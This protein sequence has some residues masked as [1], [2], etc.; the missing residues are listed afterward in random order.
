M[1]S[2]DLIL[3][4]VQS[5]IHGL[6]ALADQCDGCSSIN[7]TL[8]E[9]KHGTESLIHPALA[10]A[11]VFHIKHTYKLLCVEHICSLSIIFPFSFFLSFF[12]HV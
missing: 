3:K 10:A 12:F 7:I 4:A 8:D 6:V 9:R 11:Q 1:D 5:C 2:H